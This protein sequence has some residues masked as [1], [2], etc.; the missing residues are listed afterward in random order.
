M[1]RI[2]ERC[3]MSM[4][5]WKRKMLVKIEAEDLELCADELELRSAK[6]EPLV[7]EL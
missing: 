6:H 4:K 2:F 5:N 1:R 7:L 3:A